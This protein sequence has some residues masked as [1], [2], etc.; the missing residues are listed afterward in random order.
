[1]RSPTRCST[2]PPCR[3]SRSQTFAPAAVPLSPVLSTLSRLSA[4]CSCR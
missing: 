2:G 4:S 3:R 1:M